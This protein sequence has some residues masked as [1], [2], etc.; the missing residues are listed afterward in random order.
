MRFG[1]KL[2]R[3]ASVAAALTL[4][5]TVAL[6]GGTSDR[7]VPL[8]C[9]RGPDGQSYR[10]IVTMPTSQPVGST[11]TV[12]IDAVS[13]GPI[14]HFGLRYIYNMTADYTVPAGTTY[15]EGSARIV[16]GTGTDNVRA[17]AG[18]THD[19]GGIH[20]LLPG[21][22]DNGGSYTAP[23]IEFQVKVVGAAGST[24]SLGFQGTSV[25]ASAAII[26]TVHTACAPNPK[27]YTLASTTIVE[28]AAP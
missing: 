21:H 1:S 18:V 11:F 13:V 15:V 17:N 28:A 10:N 19:A 26:G 16:P 4:V 9:T 5:A 2:V 6:G 22:V 24:A 14:S 27:P 8:T 3:G 25:D 23:S 12:R 7:T 20:M